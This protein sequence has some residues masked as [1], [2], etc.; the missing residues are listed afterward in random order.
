MHNAC[1]GRHNVPPVIEP[2]EMRRA[3]CG[4]FALNAAAGKIQNEKYKIRNVKYEI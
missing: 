2:V 3:A 4:S 1:G